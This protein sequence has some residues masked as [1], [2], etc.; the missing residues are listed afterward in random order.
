MRHGVTGNKKVP[1]MVNGRHHPAGG[2]KTN[3]HAVSP[4][5]LRGLPPIY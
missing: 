3:A 1:L 5:E 2:K 4:T